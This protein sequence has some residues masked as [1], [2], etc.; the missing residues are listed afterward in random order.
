MKPEWEDTEMETWKFGPPT[1][2]ISWCASMLH[3]WVQV[4]LCLFSSMSSKSNHQNMEMKDPGQPWFHPHYR[5]RVRVT[6]SAGGFPPWDTSIFPSV[7]VQELLSLQTSPLLLFLKLVFEHSFAGR[8]WSCV[9][10]KATQQVTPSVFA[11]YEWNIQTAE[12][13]TIRKKIQWIFFIK[14]K[15]SLCSGL[16]V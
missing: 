7:V 5:V 13:T 10:L 8:Q 6:T 16:S 4:P 15:V 9:L 3:F 11:E 1:L 14:V 12:K 2:S